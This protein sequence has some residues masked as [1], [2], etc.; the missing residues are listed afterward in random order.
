MVVANKLKMSNLCARILVPKLLTALQHQEQNGCQSVH[1]R[2]V[3]RIMKEI[4]PEGVKRRSARRM[5]RRVFAGHTF[6]VLVRE[7]AKYSDIQQ[8]NRLIASLA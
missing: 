4:D 6:H 2:L 1:S 3:A 7:N 5:K 8:V